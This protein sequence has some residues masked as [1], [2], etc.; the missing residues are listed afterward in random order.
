MT[1]WLGL[2]D[3]APPWAQTILLA[4][5]VVIVGCNAWVVLLF[6]RSRAALRHLPHPDDVTAA[7]LLWVVM[8][9]ALDEEVTI[10]DSVGRLDA[11]EA[12][13]RVV[14]VIDDYHL[15]SNPDVNCS[16]RCVATFPTDRCRC[17]DAILP[18][19]VAARPPR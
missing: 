17:C 1:A 15:V 8:V 19:P 12:A 13:H 16:T 4:A 5:L 9:P 11:L 3:G 14:L 10:A 6:A 7:E 2:Y 18:T